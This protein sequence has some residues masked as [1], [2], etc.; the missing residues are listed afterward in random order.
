MS[1]SYKA[2]DWTPFKRAINNYLWVGISSYL[3]LF[4]LASILFTPT[5]SLNIMLIRAFGSAAFLLLHI[6]LAIGPL[7]RID[8]RFLPL[9][10]IRRHM[11]VSCF[12]LALMHGLLV[13]FTHHTGSDVH[14]LV[15]VFSSDSG[16]TIS[17]FPFQAFGAIALGI[18]L[19]MAAT[20]H[21]FWLKNL[22]APIWKSLHMLVYIAYICIIIHVT[23]GI[24]QTENSIVYFLLIFAG[25]TTLCTLHVYAAIKEFRT[26]F[27]AKTN[28][29]GD[30]VETFP[31]EDIP[32]DRARIINLHGERVAIFKHDGKIY[33]VSNVCQHQNGPLG[34][35]KIINGCITCPWHG[36]QYHP[37]NGCAKE[38]STEKIPTFNTVIK[39]GVVWV[40]HKPNLPGSPVKPA[41]IHEAH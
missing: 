35:G 37:E 1:F 24:L 10:Y 34:E 26:D 28:S 23:M 12:I 22:S 33:A 36:M 41:V 16:S 8:S 21:D 6:I 3:A 14:P 30:L 13:I 39:D 40:D 4:T 18:M 15:S 32:E 19:V 27:T 7:C 29:D 31:V 2:I 20:S 38:P 9:L 25:V 17:T 5:I 11:G